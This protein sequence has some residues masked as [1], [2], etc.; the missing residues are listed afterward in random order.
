MANDVECFLMCLLAICTM[1]SLKKCI[2]RSFTHLFELFVFLLLNCKSHLYILYTSLLSDT[3]F[4]KSFFHHLG[5]S[6]YFLDDA[7]CSTHLFKFWHS[8]IYLFFLW[9]LVLF[10][11]IATKPLPNPSNKLFIPM[12][13]LKNFRVLHVTCRFLIC[14]ELIFPDGVR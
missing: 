9:L 5:C 8:P 6:F 12:V 1:C 7:V 2:F 13:F 4:V 3:W 10:D 14:F 11:F